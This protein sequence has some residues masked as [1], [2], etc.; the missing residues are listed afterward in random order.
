MRVLLVGGYRPLLTALKQGLEEEAIAVD[1]IDVGRDAQPA[2]PP[3]I[4][5]AVVLDLIRPNDH[6]LASLQRWRR[7]GLGGFVIALTPPT[8]QPT[9]D[10]DEC[11][12]TPFQ[13]DGLLARLRFAVR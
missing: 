2:T 9:N 10:I 8:A 7:D 6:A 11:L 12:I 4:Y 13:I 1:V 3:A 5:D